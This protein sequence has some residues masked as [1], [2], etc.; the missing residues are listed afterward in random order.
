VAGYMNLPEAEGDCRQWLTFSFD[1]H[2]PAG[3]N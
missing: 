2:I 3:E 1:D